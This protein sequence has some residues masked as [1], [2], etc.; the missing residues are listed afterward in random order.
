MT[1]HKKLLS[2][3]GLLYDAAS[4]QGQWE[5]FLD[6]FASVFSSTFCQLAYRDKF[7][8]QLS[9]V[10]MVG[11]D[12]K[13]VEEVFPTY[14]QLILKDPRVAFLVNEPWH[15][16]YND[17]DKNKY[18]EKMNSGKAYRCRE[19]ISSEEL[20]K[21]EMYQ[22]VLSVIGLEY[23][24]ST[25]FTLSPSCDAI[26]GLV[27]TEDE[28][29]FTDEDCELL[30]ELRPHLERA[31][32]LYERLSQFDFERRTALE[33][34][35]S[36]GMGVVLVDQDTSL[37]YANTMAEEIA[38]NNVDTIKI[39]QT[40][41]FANTEYTDWFNACVDE[42]INQSNEGES[43]TARALRITRESAV[44][45]SLMVSRLSG[46]LLNSRQSKPDRPIAI[47]YISDPSREVVVPLKLYKRLYLLTNA[48]ARIMHHIVNGMKVTAIAEH[49]SVSVATIRK[50]LRQVFEKTGT[51]D[52]T[53]LVRHVM[54]GPAWVNTQSFSM[55]H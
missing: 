29:N 16:R 49:L 21:F 7:N 11:G 3:L 53:E 12:K 41:L 14:Q 5:P 46:D 45:L 42:V 28:G 22:K 13:I 51:A 47:V 54:S 30:N 8:D 6:E 1:D 4:N 9:F 35:N 17:S 20:H 38:T 2:I 24:M 27:R 55:Q 26:I 31:V 34:L 25:Y 48:E 36:I 43:N 40:L 37:L 18:I 44:P 23:S 10:S 39:G 19:I 52:Q 33:S 50:H 32:N 15:P